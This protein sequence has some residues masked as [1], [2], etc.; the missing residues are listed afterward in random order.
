MNIIIIEPF[1]EPQEIKKKYC[2]GP[3]IYFTTHRQQ[4]DQKKRGDKK[5]FYYLPSSKNRGGGS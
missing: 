4:R 3:F 2:N 5:P 1:I